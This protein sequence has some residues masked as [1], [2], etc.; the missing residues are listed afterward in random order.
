VISC[1]PTPTGSRALRDG[2]R[3]VLGLGRLH[4]L[5]AAPR[6]PPP[7]QRWFDVARASP[8]TP[9][10]P[11]ASPGGGGPAGRMGGSRTGSGEIRAER[12]LSG[13]E[14]VGR[15]AAGDPSREVGG[16]DEG[17]R[18]RRLSSPHPM[19]VCR[20]TSGRARRARARARVSE[21]VRP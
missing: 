3:R 21:T 11:P 9:P 10:P 7:A 5:V 18:P 20:S 6:C 16:S 15:A 8:A 1:R 19:S 4:F 17:I 12:S 13:A 14:V 2:G